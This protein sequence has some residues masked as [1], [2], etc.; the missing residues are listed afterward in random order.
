M[1]NQTLTLFTA[2]LFL[3]SSCHQKRQSVEIELHD[4][5]ME[6]ATSLSDEEYSSFAENKFESALDHPLSTFSIDVDT[7]SYS[8]FRRFINQGQLPP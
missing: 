7:D 4:I 8:N 3:F 1:R 6:A 2:A 5:D